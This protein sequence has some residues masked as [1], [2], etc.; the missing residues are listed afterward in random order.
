[1]QASDLWDGRWSGAMPHKA[2]LVQHWTNAQ[3][4]PQV[5][6]NW[7]TGKGDHEIGKFRN[8]LIYLLLD[9]FSLIKNKSIWEVFFFKIA[10]FSGI[11]KWY[12]CII[13]NF[14]EYGCL[15]K[16]FLFQ[17]KF[18]EGKFLSDYIFS[19]T[20]KAPLP[21]ISFVRGCCSR[22]SVY[23]SLCSSDTTSSAST[24][25]SRRSG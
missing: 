11:S 4:V 17:L 2:L 25:S 14:P 23:S 18:L 8:S 3:R 19:S 7:R 22:S 9:C 1:M 6:Q 15:S 21:C 20:W 24:T 12:L 16:L 13:L 10:Y 5:R